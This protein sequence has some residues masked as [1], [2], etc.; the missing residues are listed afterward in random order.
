MSYA[1]AEFNFF[2]PEVKDI[3]YEKIQKL[4]EKGNV[5]RFALNSNGKGLIKR[6]LEEFGVPAAQINSILAA[7][8][9]VVGDVKGAIESA[10]RPADD[11]RVPRERPR[12][13]G[14]GV[15][16]AAD[17]TRV[18]R[19]RAFDTAFMVQMTVLFKMREWMDRK[20]PFVFKDVDEY[21]F[22]T[23]DDIFNHLLQNYPRKVNE[24]WNSLV[25]TEEEVSKTDRV[26]AAMENIRKRF[27]AEEK[28]TDT[29]KYATSI[30]AVIVVAA[31]MYYGYQ[32]SKSDIEWINRNTN[33]SCIFSNTTAST[34]LNERFSKLTHSE[35]LTDAM[36]TGTSYIPFWSLFNTTSNSGTCPIFN[37]DEVDQ[38]FD[39]VQNDTLSGLGNFLDAMINENLGKYKDQLD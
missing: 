13:S 26:A 22:K 2:K 9:V 25:V 30:L 1:R 39:K 15:E 14:R 27:N 4:V 37:K 16:F 23:L 5:P 10:M 28:K 11:G 20:Y 34:Y 33:T 12:A 24:Y 18:P 21:E 29:F 17:D 35:T 3:S 38:T 8:S 32:V 6:L 19:R 36:G 31:A 7:E